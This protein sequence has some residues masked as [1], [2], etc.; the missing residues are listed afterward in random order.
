[1]NFVSPAKV[2]GVTQ[3]REDVREYMLAVEKA[4]RYNPG[5]FVQ[6]TLDQVS[7]SDIWPDSRTFSIASYQPGIMRLI[8]Q[9]VGYYTTRI[10]T[11]LQAGSACT[12]KYPF[13]DLFDRNSLRE[14]H[15]FIAGGLGITPF[16]GL[17]RYFKDM[18]RENQVFLFYS[19]SY[20]KD[21][22]HYEELSEIFGKNMKLFV[23]REVVEGTVG[24]RVKLEDIAQQANSDTNCYLCGSPSFNLDYFELLRGNSFS[25]IRMDEWE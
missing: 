11:E 6:L 20:F 15:L 3:I 23:T 12:I 1:M 18:G 16:L 5:S 13:G 24:H 10:F 8:I 7:A 22:V 2:I 25:K 19:V 17:G 14:K 4:R 21:L 9:R